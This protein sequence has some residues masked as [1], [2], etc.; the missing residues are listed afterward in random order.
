M[1]SK[2][3]PGTHPCPCGS[4]QN[5]VDCCA[6]VI[7]GE[8]IAKTAEA[9]MRSRYTA[10]VL[11]NAGYLAASWHPSTRPAQLDVS[12]QIEWLGLDVRACRAGL[13]ADTKGTVEFIARYR[14]QDGQGQVRENSRFVK[15]QGVWFYLDG[16][17][18]T[19]T[20]G[21]NDPCICGSGKKFKKCCGQ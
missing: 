7:A 1:Q 5:L 4:G 16:D 13:A 17:L 15:E 21:R 3:Q 9:L 12:G 6:P 18:K 19:A 2:N 20:A 11:G 8:S 10:Y 14:Q